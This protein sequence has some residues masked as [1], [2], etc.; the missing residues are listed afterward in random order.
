VDS[1]GTA[2]PA[3]WA[4]CAGQQRPLLATSGLFP[5][6]GR[7]W[8]WAKG[9]SLPL[10]CPPC[11]WICSVSLRSK[12]KWPLQLSTGSE[13]SSQP[14]RTRRRDLVRAEGPQSAGTWAGRHMGRTSQGLCLPISSSEPRQNPKNTSLDV[15][16]C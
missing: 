1:M 12:D 14:S 5:D 15:S 9:G 2:V 16:S 11:D 4:P 10:G 7:R 3:A 8:T 6:L 13:A